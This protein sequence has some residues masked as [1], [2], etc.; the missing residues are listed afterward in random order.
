MKDQERLRTVTDRT[1]LRRWDNECEERFGI[2]PWKRK[3]PGTG[4]RGCE[5]LQAER[6]RYPTSGE[7]FRRDKELPRR[8]PGMEKT[9]LGCNCVEIQCVA[10]RAPGS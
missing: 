2:T 4:L 7:W 1:R 5:G 3:G 8:R 6:L 9:L 10:E